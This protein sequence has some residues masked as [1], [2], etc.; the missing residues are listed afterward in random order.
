MIMGVRY[1]AFH[2][3]KWILVHTVDY[4][5]LI[6][7]VYSFIG[8]FLDHFL[9][10]FPFNSISTNLSFCVL[11]HSMRSPNLI[12]DIGDN[13]PHLSVNKCFWG[14]HVQDD[15]IDCWRVM[16]MNVD[17]EEGNTMGDVSM[18]DQ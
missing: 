10:L 13:Q 8:D 17:V 12:I 14:R 2:N 11:Q 15:D 4:W 1:C 16:I 7:C 9:A 18:Y 3:I 6:W 5:W